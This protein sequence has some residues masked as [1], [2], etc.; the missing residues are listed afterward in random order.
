MRYDCL[1]PRA[2]DPAL[3][4]IV[5]APLVRWTKLDCNGAARQH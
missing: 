5:Q 4:L 2:E 3:E 1:V